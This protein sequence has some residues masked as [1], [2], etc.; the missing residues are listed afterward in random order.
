MTISGGTIGNDNEYAYDANNQLSHTKGGNVFAGGMGRMYKLDGTTPISSLDWW[1][2]G[3]VKSTKLTIT[4]GTIKSNIFVLEGKYQFNRKLTL[5]AEAQWLH[6]KQDQKDWWFGLLELSVLPKLMFTVSD[7]FNAH[8]PEGGKANA[9][10]HPVHYWN[11]SCTF[12]HKSHR[13]QAGY[14]KTRA[15]FNCS[16]GVCRWVPAQKGLQL[17]YSYS[18]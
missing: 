15:G 1:K 5:R 4:G 7:E 8:V 9:P 10:T 16:G 2:L 14:G 11:V 13:L 17:S 3:C 18:F 6:T 12:T